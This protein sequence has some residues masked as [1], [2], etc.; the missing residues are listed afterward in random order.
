MAMFDFSEEDVMFQRMCRDFC[1]KE[2]RPRY[3]ANLSETSVPTDLVK[4]MGDVGMFGLMQPEKYGGQPGSFVM[5]GIIAEELSRE[6]FDLGMLPAM[7]RTVCDGAMT[8]NE[9]KQKEIM[10][11]S[12]SGDYICSFAMTEPEVGSDA[13]HMR[14]RA[15]KDGDDYILNGEKTSISYAC[16]AEY[17]LVFGVTDPSKGVRGVNAFVVPFNSTGIERTI[18]PYFGAKGMGE[19]SVIFDNV[20]LPADY[21]VGEEG[22]GFIWG[23]QDLDWMRSSLAL[24]DAGLAMIS[25]EETIEYVKERKAFGRPIGKFEGVSFKIVEDLAEVEAGR[26]LAY[27][28]LWLTDVGR[29]HEATDVNAMAKYFL[30][31]ACTKAIWDC[32]LLHGYIGYSEEYPLM[33]RMVD[34]ISWQIGDGTREVMD[35]ILVRDLI[36]RDYVAYR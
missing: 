6:F 18:I 23:M 36:G 19:S 15:T 17:G 12:I 13:A 3:T 35:T 22:A 8:L 7:A 32:V 5:L 28:S 34:S 20:R 1:V 27:K 33:R 26:L 31:R 2:L 11:K 10:P 9:E 14:L 30:P 4:R 21:R 25:L 29:H 24:Q 16:Q